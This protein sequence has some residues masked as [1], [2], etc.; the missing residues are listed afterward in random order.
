MPRR[1]AVRRVLDHAG[2]L[3][4]QVLLVRH[5]A[6]G[7]LRALRRAEAA[8]Q[9]RR[10]RPHGQ[11][12]SAGDHL[13]VA[14]V[15][16]YLLATLYD[17]DDA[18][19]ALLRGKGNED[20]LY[21]ELERGAPPTIVTFGHEYELIEQPAAVVTL[22]ADGNATAAARAAGAAAGG[23]GLA[24][25]APLLCATAAG[26]NESVGGAAPSWAPPLPPSLLALADEGARVGRAVGS[27]DRTSAPPPPPTPPPPTPPPPTAPPPPARRRP[28]PPPPSSPA[29][30][31]AAARSPARRRRRRR[32]TFACRGRRRR[33]PAHAAWP[34]RAAAAGAR[35]PTAAEPAARRPR[36]R[37]SGGG[38]AAGGGVGLFVA[39]VDD[40][41]RPRASARARGLP[42]GA[43]P[44]PRA[45]AV[46][47]G[48]LRR[49]VGPLR[50]AL[51][52]GPRRR[53]RRRGLGRAAP[54][55]HTLE[56]GR[57]GAG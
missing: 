32:R 24:W 38:G 3:A 2:H 19:S 53:R 34:L 17:D 13:E 47:V 29:P 57:A 45:E 6:Q 42:L 16:S 31:P 44:A 14:Y 21:H 43:P 22:A 12:G 39:A 41:P 35:C 33:P 50:D 1:H 9:G 26:A 15:V 46:L 36:A 40:A 55:T 54:L 25:L 5:G 56:S 4:A 11:R 18:R 10:R 49:R 51:A 28:P 7:V 30:A 8:H 52:L 37:R 27:R 20:I 23:G 48:R